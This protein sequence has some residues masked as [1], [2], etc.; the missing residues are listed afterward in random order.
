MYTCSAG[1]KVDDITVADV[2]YPLITKKIM[3]VFQQQLVHLRNGCILD[4]LKKLPD[5]K[6]NTINFHNTGYHVPHYQSLCGTS[7]V[8]SLCCIVCSIP[9]GVLVL[10]YL[11]PDW[12]GGF[13]ATTGD[14]SGHL[15]EKYQPPRLVNF[16][17]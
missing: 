6:I 9:R 5:V 11:M 2:A 14:I 7:K 4:N 12:V 13:W 8:A 3:G 10:K 17:T 15:I 1:M 16:F